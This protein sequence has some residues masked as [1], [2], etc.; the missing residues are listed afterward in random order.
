MRVD[1]HFFC[2]CLSAF[3]LPASP[4]FMRLARLPFRPQPFSIS[5]ILASLVVTRA[6]CWR[7]RAR[8]HRNTSLSPHKQLE[9]LWKKKKSR[10]L[11]CLLAHRGA[12]LACQT[13][14]TRILHYPNASCRSCQLPRW[15]AGSHEINFAGRARHLGNTGKN[16]LRI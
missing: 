6:E 2:V 3:S 1:P 11:A 7:A 8:A 5:P 9:R 4:Q 14:P 16:G 13:R 15:R 12:S 10:L